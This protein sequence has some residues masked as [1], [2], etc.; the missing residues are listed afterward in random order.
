MRFRIEE[1]NDLKALIE[2]A[3]LDYASFSFVK[4]KGHLYIRHPKAENPF[5]LFRG[6]ETQMTEDRKMVPVDQY[7]V[8]AGKKKVAVDSWEKVKHAFSTW[9]KQ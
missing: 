1:H 6:K 2:N 9:L 3:G 7:Y 4:S 5:V 8:G